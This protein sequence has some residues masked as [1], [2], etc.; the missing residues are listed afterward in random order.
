MTECE[1]CNALVSA[2]PSQEYEDHLDAVHRVSSG[3]ALDVS[4]LVDKNNNAFPLEEAKATKKA[5]IDK[6]TEE[7]CSLGF[8]YDGKTFSLSLDAQKNY[9]G[10]KMFETLMPDPTP[11]AAM[12][13]ST[14]NLAKSSFGAFCGAALA[15]VQSHLNSRL[16]FLAAVEAASTPEDVMAVVDTR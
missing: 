16:P 7:L 10:M 1:H 6:R 8:S 15:M 12:D 4:K 13:G 11:I 5:D 9:I 3:G 2:I 14:Y